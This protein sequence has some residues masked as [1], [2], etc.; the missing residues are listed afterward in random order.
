LN[1]PSSVFLYPLRHRRPPARTAWRT[2]GVSTNTSAVSVA[3]MAASSGAS[4]AGGKSG[5]GF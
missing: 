1:A 3:T 4:V 2:R 5:S